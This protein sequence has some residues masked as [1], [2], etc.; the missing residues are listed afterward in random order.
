MPGFYVIRWH[1]VS[2]S[3]VIDPEGTFKLTRN[4]RVVS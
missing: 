4:G 2:L 3:G 1:V